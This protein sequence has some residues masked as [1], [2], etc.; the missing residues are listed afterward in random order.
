MSEEDLDARR[1]TE[2]LIIPDEIAA[3][4]DA[5]PEVGMSTETRTEVVVTGD[6]AVGQPLINKVETTGMGPNGLQELIRINLTA[7][8]GCQHILHT[9]AE[10]G[11]ICSCGCG[12]L[13]C[14]ACASKNLCVECRRPVAGSCQRRSAL[15]PANEI[16]C[17]HCSRRRW[18]LESSFAAFI[19][20]LVGIF[21]LIVL[22]TISG[23]LSAAFK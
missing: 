3:D 9:G 15:S 5:A 19:A 21:A 23:A 8:P 14:T 20:V 22:G 10:V 7:A 17:P 13:L 12:R 1:E 16:L 18:T 4:P 11:G 6:G 2:P